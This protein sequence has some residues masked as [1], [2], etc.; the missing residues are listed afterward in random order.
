MVLFLLACLVSFL[1]F[2]AL[3]LWFRNHIKREAAFQKLCD[4][5]LLWGF[6]CVIPVVLLSGISHLVL[7]L[8]G[9]KNTNPLLYD[10]L[11]KFIVL[12]LA[13]EVVKYLMFRRVLHKTDVPYSWLDATVLMTIVGIGFGWIESVTYA[14]GA[15]I[16]VVLVRGICVPHAGYGFLIGYFYDKGVK[17]GKSVEKWIG[18][19]LAWLLH[20]LYDFSLSERFLALNDNLAFVPFLLALLDIILVILLIVF[21]QKAKKRERYTEPLFRKE[22]LTA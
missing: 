3:F 18:F 22:G 21:V 9:V 7:S 6:F 4:K 17:T 15:T 11:Y 13:E 10:A 2:I 8:T 16:P 1:P 14:F 19:A 5:A 20:G 12:A